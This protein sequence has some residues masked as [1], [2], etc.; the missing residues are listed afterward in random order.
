MFSTEEKGKFIFAEKLVT[1]IWIF[2]HLCRL[3]F[4]GVHLNF[5]GLHEGCFWIAIACMQ[6]APSRAIFDFV[7]QNLFENDE[8]WPGLK[9]PTNSNLFWNS[10]EATKIALKFPAFFI[11]LQKSGK[12]QNNRNLFG[13]FWVFPWFKKRGKIQIKLN[14]MSSFQNRFCFRFALCLI[15]RPE[16]RRKICGKKHFF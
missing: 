13:Y 14:I 6:N 9:F 3:I 1:Q 7:E 5:L 8:N 4:S 12:S 2:C 11:L 15:G 16:I 10:N